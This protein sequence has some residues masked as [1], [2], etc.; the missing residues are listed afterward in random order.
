M[1]KCFR[2]FSKISTC[3][4]QG[5]QAENQLVLQQN[6]LVTDERTSVNIFTADVIFGHEMLQLGGRFTMSYMREFLGFFFFFFLET[7]SCLK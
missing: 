1:G 3:S 6:P 7:E 2:Y 4:Y 5:K